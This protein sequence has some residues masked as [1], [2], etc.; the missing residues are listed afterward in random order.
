MGV[1]NGRSKRVYA[2]EHDPMGKYFCTLCFLLLQNPGNHD[3]N[4]QETSIGSQPLNVNHKRLEASHR[5]LLLL[6]QPIQLTCPFFWAYCI[7]EYD[8]VRI[9]IRHYQFHRAQW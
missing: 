4:Q 7:L 9:I 8:E 3:N 6:E 1:R 5:S 2:L